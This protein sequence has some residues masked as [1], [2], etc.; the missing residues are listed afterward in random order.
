MKKENVV[1]K[2]S[3]FEH[4]APSG[5]GWHEVPGE[6]VLTKEHFIDTPSS[7]LWGTSKVEKPFNTP[8]PRYAV[9]PPQGGQKKAALCTKHPARGEVNGGFTLIELLIVVL[10]I[11][12]LAAMAVPQYQKAVQKARL[13]EFGA[14]ARTARQAIDTYL[15]DNGFPESI[16]YFTGD[17]NSHQLP[18]EIPGTICGP[19]RNQHCTATGAFD[20]GCMPSLCGISLYTKYNKDGSTGNSWL[21][22]GNI[23][24]SRLGTN[25]TWYLSVVPTDKSARRVV[26]QW[27][28][29]PFIDNGTPSFTAKTDCAQVGVE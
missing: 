18:I 16:T 1:V 26:C 17:N 20:V 27:W 22:E 28:Q 5:R 15:L 29:G 3:T 7:P 2:K 4:L 9:L 6:G 19:N 11:G 13:S 24:I 14:V 21:K 12:I 8:L 10:I 23:A 25:P